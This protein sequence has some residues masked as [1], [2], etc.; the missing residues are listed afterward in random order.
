MTKEFISKE[1]FLNAENHSIMHPTE[2][3]IDI[4]KFDSLPVL[5]VSEM[6]LELYMKGVNMGG[7][8]QGCWVRFK[9]IEKVIIKYLGN[10]YSQDAKED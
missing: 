6:M 2:Y 5:N 7:E 10:S 8:Y 4:D 1:D 9:D 3:V